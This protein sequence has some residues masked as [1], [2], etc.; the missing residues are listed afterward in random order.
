MY[1]SRSSCCTHRDLDAALL[2]IEELC[3]DDPCGGL[4]IVMVCGLCG[5]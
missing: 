4:A 1:P 5:F 2:T 3:Y